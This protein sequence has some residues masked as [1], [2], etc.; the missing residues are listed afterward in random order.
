MKNVLASLILMAAASIAN[1][2][3]AG[4]NIA[5]CPTAKD[6]SGRVGYRLDCCL[7]KNAPPTSNP[8]PLARAGTTVFAIDEELSVSL[9][10]ANTTAF[11]T[12]YLDN[13]G[14]L[15]FSVSAKDSAVPNAK[16]CSASSIDFP[17]EISDLLRFRS[18]SVECGGSS[19]EL[20]CGGG[21]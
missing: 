7:V 3:F 8:V 11:A 5:K 17:N 2:A 10:S 1:S 14:V 18:L 15:N 19:Y 6:A 4:H 21:C 16:S 9:G 12:F 13:D 20:S